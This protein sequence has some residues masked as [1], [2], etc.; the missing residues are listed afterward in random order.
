MSST[1]RQNK[2]IVAEDWKKIYQSFKN[3]DFKSYDFDNLRRTMIGY[4]R[5]NYPEDFND[6]IESSEY[7]ALIDMIAFLGQNLAFRFDLNSRDNFL[8]LAERRESILRLARLLSYNSKRSVSAS[9]LLKFTTVS[10][11]EQLVDSNGRNLAKQTIVW[12]D[13]ANPNWY[14]QF[15]KVINASLP[16]TSQYGNPIDSAYISGIPVDQYRFN[17]TNSGLP[18]YGFNKSIDGRSMNFEVVSSTF[19]NSN[20]I[21]EE[22][23]LQGNSFAFLYRDDGKGPASSNT[24]FFSM[25]KQ[26]NLQSAS[27]SV[28]NPS[29]NESVNIDSPNI[30]ND[31]V[32]LYGLDAYGIESTLWN[33]VDAVVGNNVI[34]NSLKKNDRDIF[35]VLTRTGDRISMVFADGLFGNLPN[36]SFKSYYRVSNNLSYSINPSDIR[37]VSV[38][39]PYQSISGSTETLTI[40]MSL[41][42]T[43]S[44]ASASET[45]A[46][47]KANAPA[48]YY[49]Q[50]RMITGEDYNVLPP[51]TNQEIAKIKTLNRV[52]SGISRY[53]DLVDAT[54]MYSHTNIFGVDGVVYKEYYTDKLQFSSSSR[55]DISNV[56]VNTIQ[57][58]INRANVRDFYYDQY[59]YVVVRSGVDTIFKQVTKSANSSTGYFVDSTS[60]SNPKTIG[61]F[62][63]SNLRYVVIG[64]LLKYVA[65][66]GKVFDKNNNLI[67]PPSNLAGTSTYIWA[68]VVSVNGDGTANGT[69][70]LSNGMGPVVL[71]IIVPDDAILSEIIPKY[72]LTLSTDVQ[73]KMNDLI[74]SNKEFGL[75]YDTSTLSWKIITQTNLDKVSNFG[76]AKTGDTSNKNADASWIIL[77]EVKGGVYTVTNR[78]LR[79]VFESAQ[80]V[81]FFFDATEKVYDSKTGRIIK[82]TI[83]VLSVNNQPDASAAFSS[84]IQWNV[85]DEYK[86]ADGYIDTK[87]I[88]I[89]FTDDNDDGIVDNPDI[90]K[91]IVNPTAN[92]SSKIV[93]EHRRVAPDGSIDFY[94]IDNSDGLITIIDTAGSIN[95]MTLA[96]N[97]L[98][99]IMDEGVVKTYY[100]GYLTFNSEYKGYV[101]RDYLK[102]QYVHASGDTSRL[103]P[104][105]TNI[106]DMYVL[107]KSYDSVY[108]SWIIGNT[109]Q[110]PLPPSSDDLYVN[111]GAKLGAI[112]ATS[113]EII[114]HPVKYKNLFGSTADQTLQGTFK[115]V[116][117]P[118][119]VSSD[120]DVISRVLVSINEFFTLDNWDFGDTFY[121]GELSTY[122]MQQHA[123]LISNIVLVP[124]Q[125]GLA[126]GS[127]YEIQSNSDE[128]F[129]SSATVNDIEII[130][131]ITAKELNASGVVV[132]GTLSDTSSIQ[133]A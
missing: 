91:E 93:F 29:T 69:G 100:K 59:D 120:N 22:P 34:Y 95:G 104:S 58:I 110:M 107:T 56:I 94:Y 98:V 89:S 66:E 86:G 23:P 55:T 73:T 131:E 124:K 24:G 113:D 90:F 112:K 16:N 51:S 76:T 87:K 92:T 97:S 19:N 75:R 10:T 77:F 85:V 54:G 65:P 103:D 102:F 25:F 26:G 6:Y 5:E 1:D 105:S 27:F 40:T 60:V 130:S 57:P 14:E 52:S 8:E 32:W 2:L 61:T 46:S 71:S 132:T 126:F 127:L 37:N 12:N 114:Y 96:D 13:P 49:T 74:F 84:D 42:Y 108:R 88:S 70:V 111:F 119:V 15:I 39:I 67:T 109:D 133:S 121:F 17:A 50:G 117:N 129:I 36:G 125:G 128:I 28:T 30:N 81:R 11:T 68:T 99:Y 116:K 48:T 41:K 83:S 106:M 33:K 118:S 31:D 47:I 62:T 4:L 35:S 3:A 72:T 115:V 43:V 44:N 21:Y 20:A 38:N 18:V 123:P 9:G 82:D 79:Y 53:F 64:S 45:S 101:G 80:E 7:L 122:I 63:S 78:S